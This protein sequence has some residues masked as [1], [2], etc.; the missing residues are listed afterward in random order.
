[1]DG[2]GSEGPAAGEGETS[3]YRRGSEGP[4]AGAAVTSLYRRGLEGPA[5][6][7]VVM[8][9]DGRGPE[10]PAAADVR[11]LWRLDR[12]GVEGLASVIS[13]KSNVKRWMIRGFGEEEKSV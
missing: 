2:R 9:L 11:T 12:R 7:D 5:P 8:S 10:E 3:L 13:E 6:G 4:A 1:V